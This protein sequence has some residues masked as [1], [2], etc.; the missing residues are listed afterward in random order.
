MSPS[1]PLK[2]LNA[3]LCILV[4][5]VS[6][7]FIVLG[8][9]ASMEFML[10]HAQQRPLSFY[11][12]VGLA[13]LAL[14]LMPFQFWTGL[15]LR[16]PKT[17]RW[18]GRVYVLAIVISGVG[19]LFM[20]VNTR[21]GLVAGTGFGLLALVWLGTTL[22]G[23][24]LARA[25]RIAEHQVWMIRSAALT[26]AAVTLRLY[27]PLSQVAGLPMEASYAAIAWACW[28]PNLIVA[29]IWIVNRIQRQVLA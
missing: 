14:L 9:E 16:R 23:I 3:L 25:K 11:A 4:A 24:W 22:R 20:A 10:Y 7:R 5:I 17:H 29:E 6:W 19:A 12:H 15:R 2:W 28:V 26:F 8:V 27:L 21:T 18:I 13:P 1:K